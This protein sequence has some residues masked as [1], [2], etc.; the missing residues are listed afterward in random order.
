M[1]MRDRIKQIR[2]AANMTQAEFSVALGLSPTSAAGWE[3][4]DAQIPTEPMRLLICKTFGINKSWLETGEGEM[5]ADPIKATLNRLAETHVLT[6][7]DIDL[8]QSFLL[9]NDKEKAM[10]C[11]IAKAIKK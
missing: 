5:M 10:F 8:I 9:L 6:A 4:K 3:K 11:D 2:K 7:Q 1:E